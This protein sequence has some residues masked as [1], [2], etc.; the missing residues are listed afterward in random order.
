[1]LKR[2]SQTEHDNKVKALA[3]H[4]IA[5]NYSNVRADVKG[6]VCPEKITWKATGSG[7]IPDATATAGRPQI[8]EVET[9]DSINDRHTE[10]Q[11]TLFAAHAKNTGG[12][13]TVVVPYGCLKIAKARL[14]QLNL[15][16]EVWE[17]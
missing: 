15:E 17:V 7:Y 16:A 1:M 11:W 10:D 5:H 3:D 9:E 4:L 13:F 2:S 6:Y 12:A 8:F 14:H